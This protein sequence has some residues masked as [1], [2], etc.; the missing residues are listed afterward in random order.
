MTKRAACAGLLL[1]GL[2]NLAAGPVWAA[3]VQ[4]DELTWTEVRDGLRAGTTTVILPVGGTEQNGPHMALGKHNFRAAFLSARIA[5]KLGNTLVAPVLTYVPEGRISPPAGHMR[6][7]GTI[8]VPEDAFAAVLAGAARSL[9]QHGFLDIVLVGDSGNYQGQ[10]KDVANRLNREWAGTL[11]RA[12]YIA[13]YYQAASVE[14]GRALRA[15]GLNEKQIGTHA[16]VADTSLMMAVDASR[17]RG[18]KLRAADSASPDLG[19]GG[20]PSQSSAALGQIGVDLITEKTVAAIRQAL[21][22]RKQAA[23]KE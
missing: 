19:L 7:P 22:G 2:M 14:F 15:R 4:L 6:F 12:H 13:E 16:A 18:E 20:D 23:K 5:D 21:S 11:A 1:A 10:L 8:S 17:V 9:R 3:S